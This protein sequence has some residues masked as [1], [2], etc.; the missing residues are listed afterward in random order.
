VD[1]YGRSTYGDGFADVYDDWYADVTDPAAT[2]AFVARRV[3]G[4]VL[5]LGSGTGRLAAPLRAAGVRVIGLD[6]S[7]AMLRRSRQ[8]DRAVPVV[9]A[10]MAEQ[11]IRRR[12]VAAVLVAFNTLFNLPTS[13][14]QRAA[15]R[16]AGD[17]VV[18]GGLVIVEAFVPAEPDPSQRDRVDIARL[19]AD[20]VVLRISRTDHAS[21]TVTGHHVE[22]RD[23][24]PVRLRPWHL[25]FTDPEGLDR[26][27]QGAGLALVERLGDWSDAPFDDGC[28]THVS[29]YRP[30]R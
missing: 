6:A 12:S 20:A 30:I 4:P 13:A 18:D 27:A 25:C 19:D 26:L 8:R 16:Q 24:A 7:D 9:L 14:G 10:D 15:L 21:G 28:S 23:G 3:T 29:V 2:A 17:A 1:G 5:E 11:P 22:L